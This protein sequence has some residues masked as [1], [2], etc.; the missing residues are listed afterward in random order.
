MSW[1]HDAA[2]SVVHTFRLPSTSSFFVL[3]FWMGIMYTSSKLV[4]HKA[5]G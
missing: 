2:G 3:D 1:R 5:V 4:E